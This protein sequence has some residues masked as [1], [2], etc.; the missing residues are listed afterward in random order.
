[1]KRHKSLQAARDAIIARATPDPVTGCLLVGGGAYIPQVVFRG[2]RRPAAA[3]V[4]EASRRHPVPPLRIVARSCHRRACIA[5]AHLRPIYGAERSAFA[6]QSQAGVEHWRAAFT[7]ADVARI[8]ELHRAGGLTN[9]AI[10]ALYAVTPA[11]IGNVIRGV[12]YR[13]A[14]GT[15][16]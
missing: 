12:S 11:T 13:D 3:V 2:R 6:G 10:A 5:R 16:R 15:G 7:L 4:W 1:M 14:I 8:C 9:R